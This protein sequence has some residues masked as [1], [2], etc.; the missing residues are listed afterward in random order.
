[1]L[2]ILEQSAEAGDLEVVATL[3]FGIAE[4]E[5]SIALMTEVSRKH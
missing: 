1:M 2:E 5:G 4:C 3:E